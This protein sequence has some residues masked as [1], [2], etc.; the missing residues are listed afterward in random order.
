MH[1][2]IVVRQQAI[3]A[4]SLSGFRDLVASD[5]LQWLFRGIYFDTQAQRKTDALVRRGALAY[6]DRNLC[7]GSHSS[8]FLCCESA[9]AEWGLACCRATPVTVSV[10]RPR[11][12]RPH[13]GLV[14]HRHT[15][16]EIVTQRDGVRLVPLAK[17][18][19][20]SFGRLPSD[21][22]NEMILR[23]VQEG[24]SDAAAI[25]ACVSPNQPRRG[26]LI[27]LLSLAGGGSHSVLEIAAVR[28]VV[29][30]YGLSALFRQQYAVEAGGRGVVM[31]FAAPEFKVNLETDGS[32]Y[33]SAPEA[34][35]RD[36]TRDLLLQRAGWYVV[37]AGYE[38]VLDHPEQVAAALLAILLERG[39]HGRPTTN[40]GRLALASL[41]S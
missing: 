38:Q 4:V 14:I 32:R 24:R 23:A 7:A 22:G 31:D 26:D 27:G 8:A 17:A 37:R 28:S 30:H 12:V 39:W 40:V 15:C 6:A 36:N 34:R 20:Q 11:S 16:L 19:V 21:R 10:P 29:K 25:R 41:T 1:P 35:R 9:G 3:S 13:A 18:L 2:G 5:R 33:H